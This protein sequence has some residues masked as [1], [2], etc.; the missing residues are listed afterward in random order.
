MGAMEYRGLI[1]LFDNTNTAI[2]SL[3]R[4]I[5]NPCPVKGDGMAGQATPIYVSPPCSNLWLGS[6]RLCGCIII[7]GVGNTEPMSQ[8]WLSTRF[9]VALGNV[10]S[11]TPS[12]E[13][14]VLKV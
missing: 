14:T 6:I 10:L 8:L 3:E 4:M 12:V 1:N 7:I 11:Q 9:A 2:H 5:T 13:N